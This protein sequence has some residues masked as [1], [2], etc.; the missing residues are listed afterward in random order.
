M[1]PDA[2]TRCFSCQGVWHPACGDWDP[3]YGVARCGRCIRIFLAWFK[4]HTKRKWGGMDF[5]AHA[6]TSI[7]AAPGPT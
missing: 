1:M 7:R 4:G 2:D 6:A 3:F 5:Y